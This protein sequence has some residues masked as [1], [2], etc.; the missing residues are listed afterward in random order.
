[1]SLAEELKTRNFSIYGQ[2]IGVLC[3]ILCI[4]LG[5]ANIFH[6]S[7][8]IIFSII[9]IVQGLVVVFVEIPFLLRICPV[10]ERFSNFIRFFNQN[11]PR[12]AFYIGMAT[13]QY[14]SLIFMTT[15]LLVPAVFLTITSMCYALAALKHQEF[16]GSSTLG[17]A[18]I[19]RQIL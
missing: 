17:G 6:A 13:I 18:G 3:I 19:A 5:I 9:C 2:W 8:V 14:C 7:L 1:M 15:S 11:W 16:T 4:A 12:A 10:T